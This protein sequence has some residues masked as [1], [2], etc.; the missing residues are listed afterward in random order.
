MGE[1]KY[2]LLLCSLHIKTIHSGTPQ[3][4]GP[5]SKIKFVPCQRKDSPA[6]ITILRD[7][8]ESSLLLYRELF[9]VVRRTRDEQVLSVILLD[10][11]VNKPVKPLGCL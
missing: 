2:G 4:Q 1:E 3:D 5:V 8:V 6:N 7:S 9:C 10:S 11:A